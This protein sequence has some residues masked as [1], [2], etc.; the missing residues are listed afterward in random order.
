MYPM[1]NYH[2]NCDIVVIYKSALNLIIRKIHD[3]FILV[4]NR[5]NIG[6]GSNEKKNLNVPCR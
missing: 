3:I 5:R 4:Q 2:V 1:Q 6:F